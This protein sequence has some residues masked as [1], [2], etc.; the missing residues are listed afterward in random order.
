MTPLIKAPPAA[1]TTSIVDVYR[2][3]EAGE[4]RDVPVNEL[5]RSPFQPRISVKQDDAF[6]ALKESVSELGVLQPLIVRKLA[7]GKFELIAGERRL[8][9]AK[10]CGH[11]KIPARVLTNVRDVTA[12][13]IALT[14]NCARANLSAWEQ[15]Q[16]LAALSRVLKK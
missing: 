6:D 11:D 9:A 16:T 15:A 2:R 1:P 7:D 8:E 3:A 13:A 10:A 12:Q 5:S 4:L 14:E